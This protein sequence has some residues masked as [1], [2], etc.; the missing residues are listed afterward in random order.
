MTAFQEML[1]FFFHIIMRFI[2]VKIQ[3]NLLIA[4]NNPVI[5]RHKLAQSLNLKEMFLQQ[6][7]RKQ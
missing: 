1:I 2:L 5:F 7:S 6:L 4:L 3:N